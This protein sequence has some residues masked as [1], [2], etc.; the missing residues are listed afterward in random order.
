M[1]ATLDIRWPSPQGAE[2]RLNRSEMRNAFNDAVI[3]E[4]DAAFAR[5]EQDDALRVVVLAGH[6]TA[7]CAGAE[8]R[9]GVSAFLNKREPAWRA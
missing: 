3:A 4:L 7:L 5:L 1:S 6:G 2:V 8:G 9:E